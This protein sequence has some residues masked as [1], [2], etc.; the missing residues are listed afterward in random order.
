MWFLRQQLSVH[1]GLIPSRLHVILVN[2]YILKH[3]AKNEIDNLINRREFLKGK[4]SSP[5]SCLLKL[6]ACFLPSTI[7]TFAD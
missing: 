1:F 3:F 6:C 2:S 4:K 7:A 5:E